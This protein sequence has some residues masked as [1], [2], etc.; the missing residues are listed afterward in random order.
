MD[1][2]DD[3]SAVSRALD[4]VRD[5]APQRLN[6]WLLYAVLGVVIAVLALV[7]WLVYAVLVPPTQP[8]TMVERNMLQLEQIVKQQPHNG[9]AWGDWAAALMDAG[10]YFK[11]GRVI[12][13]GLESSEQT[14]P[15]LLRRGQLAHL[16]GRDEE[17][18]DS[19][20]Q[21]I[22]AARA[23]RDK[24]VE[25]SRR[26]GVTAPPAP[27]DEIIDAQLLRGEILV[28]L[29]EYDE[30]VKAYTGALDEQPRL[31]DVLALRGDAYAKLGDKDRAV[32]DFKDALRFDPENAPAIKGL[33]A[34]G[35]TK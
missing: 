11:A 10:Q 30:A 24:A 23:F 29:K 31:S 27:S 18:L 15:L 32:S 28:S 9:K 3:S 6:S 25:E 2:L 20:M 33:E 17:A 16:Q 12:D 4:R 26:K 21:A 1:P 35:V 13:D 5:V 7:A 14:A 34:L 22:V 8:R 19:A